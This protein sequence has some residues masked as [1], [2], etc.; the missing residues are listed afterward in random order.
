MTLKG[1]TLAA[2]L[3]GNLLITIGG[4]EVINLGKLNN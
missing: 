4:L 3:L 2:F 1:A